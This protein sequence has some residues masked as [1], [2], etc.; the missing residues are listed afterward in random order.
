MW[1]PVWE[2]W[3]EAARRGDIPISTY[4][5]KDPKASGTRERGGGD[6]EKVWHD[7]FL[8]FAIDSFREINSIG[9]MAMVG[10]TATQ[11]INSRQMLESVI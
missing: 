2:Y 9:E 6:Q 11:G 4:A 10:P 8:F 3:I 5:C 7:P 1:G